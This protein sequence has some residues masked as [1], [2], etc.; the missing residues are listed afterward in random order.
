[1][2]TPQHLSAGAT[3]APAPPEAILEG[4]SRAVVI[5]GSEVIVGASIGSASAPDDGVNADALLSNADIA[6]YAA[7]ADGRRA[8]RAF[9][10]AMDTKI[11]IRRLIEL[12][13]RA[14]VA[15]DA[16]DVHFQPIFHVAPHG[17]VGFEAL[18]RWQHP[19]RGPV[20]PAE[21]IP[22]VEEIGLMEELGAAVLRRACAACASWPGNVNVSVNLSSSQFR[23]GNIEKTILGALEAA[24]LP[25]ERLE[26]EIT[27]ATL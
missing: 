23:H 27:E 11:Q 25:P 7:K 22:I 1:M 4:A 9:E 8:W 19:V 3:E 15:N 10:R 20:S 6:L 17:I 24:G 18:A 2:L 12:E 13:L 26:I 14:A 21:F 16:I 5:E